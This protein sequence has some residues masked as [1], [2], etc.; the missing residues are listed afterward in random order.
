MRAANWLLGTLPLLQRLNPALRRVPGILPGECLPPRTQTHVHNTLP[1]FLFFCWSRPGTRPKW[2]WARRRPPCFL[3]LSLLRTYNEKLQ[4]TSA[5]SHAELS[6][7]L[8]AISHLVKHNDFFLVFYRSC[9]GL[10]VWSS[11]SPTDR[12]KHLWIKT[13]VL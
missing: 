2:G 6:D 11:L 10:E 1:F 3:C 4:S 8:D 7:T 13:L 9:Y 5:W 12:G